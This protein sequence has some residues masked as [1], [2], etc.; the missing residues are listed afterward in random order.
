MTHS[1]KIKTTALSV[2]DAL[3]YLGQKAVSDAVVAGSD[4]RIIGG[5]MLR[6]LL[7][8]YPTPAAIPRSTIDADAALDSLE[9]VGPITIRPS[10]NYLS[11]LVV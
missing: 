1:I 6:L 8:T 4:Y 2:A 5:H 3:G 11:G 10:E 9:V 7:K